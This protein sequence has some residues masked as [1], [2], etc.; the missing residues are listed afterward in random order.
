[1]KDKKLDK[2]LNDLSH[3]LTFEEHS[4]KDAFYFA[5]IAK[6]FE[7]ALEYSWKHLKLRVEQEGLDVTSPKDAIR[8]AGQIGIIDNVE[9][10]IGFLDARNLAVHDYL[11]IPN[12]SYIVIAKEFLLEARKIK[13]TQKQ[14]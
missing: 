13:Q 10:W 8:K 3:A 7:V 4:R 5:G 2:S 1:M 6:S 14:I 12:D 11:G 9:G